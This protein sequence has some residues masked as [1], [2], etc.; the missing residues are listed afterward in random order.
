[1]RNRFAEHPTSTSARRNGVG[2][3]SATFNR[4]T[5]LDWRLH[6]YCMHIRQELSPRDFERRL[7]FARWL[8]DRCR[9]NENFLRNF[10]VSAEA[11]FW[12]NGQVNS[13]NVR[14]YTPAGNPPAFNYDVSCSRQKWTV[15][16]GLCGN[17]G[18]IGPF[19]F[20]RSVSGVNYLQMINTDVFRQ[21]LQHFQMQA[22]GTFR[23][24]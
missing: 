24:L 23:H 16:L 18:V 8:T 20:H 14:V 2:I 10:V 6:P 21:L 13:R 3:P 4:I 9:R 19:F 7:N 11:T 17:G 22:G 1:M 15:W 12:M 5:R